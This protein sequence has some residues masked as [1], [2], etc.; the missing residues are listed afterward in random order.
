MDTTSIIY[1]GHHIDTDEDGTVT[2]YECPP[3]LTTYE[4]GPHWMEY[5]VADAKESIDEALTPD[6]PLPFGIV[7]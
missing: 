4:G 5:S 6:K 7:L 3:G 2:V 1:K